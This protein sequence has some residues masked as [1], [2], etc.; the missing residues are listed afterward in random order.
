MAGGIMQENSNQNQFNPSQ[1]LP[2]K[3]I[4]GALMAGA[5]IFAFIALSQVMATGSEAVPDSQDPFMIFGFPGMEVTGIVV[6][7]S[8]LVYI[9]APKIQTAITKS[10]LQQGPDKLTAIQSGVIVRMVMAEFIA[11]LG[12]V[13]IF[14]SAPNAPFPAYAWANYFPLLLLYQAGIE[15]FPTEEK[16]ANKIKELENQ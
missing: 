10:A 5:T 16:I 11:L 13:F 3:I 15:N 14:L 8:I 12:I 2:L 6:V 9:V 7:L 1:I 4:I